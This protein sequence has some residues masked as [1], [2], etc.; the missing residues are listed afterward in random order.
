MAPATPNGWASLRDHIGLEHGLTFEFMDW[1]QD[2]Q[3]L[4]EHDLDHWENP[5]MRTA[6]GPAAC[7]HPTLL[8]L[9]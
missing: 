1:A 3:L 7:R 2:T 8:D 6:G 9:L 5:P 4:E